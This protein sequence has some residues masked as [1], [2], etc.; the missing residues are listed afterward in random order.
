MSGEMKNNYEDI[1]TK[2]FEMAGIE[3]IETTRIFF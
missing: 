3:D 2:N 1:C